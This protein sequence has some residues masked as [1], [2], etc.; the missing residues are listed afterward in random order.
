M[1][2]LSCRRE[3]FTLSFLTSG[4]KSPII[5][6]FDLTATVPAGPPDSSHTLHNKGSL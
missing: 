4:A 2:F 5:R 1:V 6:R 3:V